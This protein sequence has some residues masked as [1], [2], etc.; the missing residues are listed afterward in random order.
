MLFLLCLPLQGWSSILSFVTNNVYFRAASLGTNS[1]VFCRAW[2]HHAN[3]HL[4]CLRE[5]HLENSRNDNVRTIFIIYH[6]TQ[7]LVGVHTFQNMVP[8][9]HLIFPLLQPE[10]GEIFWSFPWYVTSKVS[11]AYC[12]AV[13]ISVYW[14]KVWLLPLELLVL[15]N[16]AGSF[17]MFGTISLLHYSCVSQE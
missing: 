7:S 10:W 8:I 12:T 13:F 14:V 6:S 11:K 4:P 17:Q 2:M 16:Y 9:I 3:M 1:I 5:S 15:F